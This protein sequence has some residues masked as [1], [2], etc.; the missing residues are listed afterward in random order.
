MIRLILLSLSFLILSCESIPGEVRFLGSLPDVPSDPLS[1]YSNMSEEELEKA[2][3]NGEAEAMYLLGSSLCCGA[4]TSSAED[5][6]GYELMCEAAK[7]G[8]ARAQYRLGRLFEKGISMKEINKYGEEA[9]AIPRDIPKAYMWYI[10]GEDSHYELSMHA[11]KR[12]KKKM[13]F[14]Q[15]NQALRLYKAWDTQICTNPSS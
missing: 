11:K 3:N 9:F 2:A 4:N 13:N 12:L 15:L 6:R 1:S 5:F 10:V 14:D 8:H 7:K